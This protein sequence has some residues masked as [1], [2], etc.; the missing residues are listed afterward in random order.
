MTGGLI[1]F[2]VEQN[3]TE[4]FFGQIVGVIT[5]SSAAFTEIINIYEGEQSNP[6]IANIQDE[7]RELALMNNSLPIG[8]A[9]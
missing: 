1:D 7:V 3:F 6:M 2:L 4:K 5:N 8:D 9:L